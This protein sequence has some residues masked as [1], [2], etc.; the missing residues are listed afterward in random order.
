MRYARCVADGREFYAIVEGDEAVEISDAPWLAHERGRRHPISSVSW[1]PPVL[2]PTFYAA[3]FNYKAHNRHHEELGYDPVKVGDHPE[4]G[5]RAQSA[6]AAHGDA[7]VKPDGVEGRFETEAEVVA[8]IGTTLKHAT[9]HEAKAAV[10]GWTI[11]NDVSARTWQHADRTFYRAKNADT[12][13]PMGPWIE[14]DV[15]PMASTTTVRRNGVV[16]AVFATGD[17]I[18]DPY[19]FIVEMTKYI[20]LRPGDV[21][22]MGADGNTPMGVGDVID[23]EIT[24]IGTLTN[25]VAAE[26]RRTDTLVGIQ[27]GHGR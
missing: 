17:M 25:T 11:G 8:V 16:D 4:V 1:L 21:L 10:F 13:K 9:R 12:F 20:T 27:K 26:G 23:I 18:F 7:I 22:W 3:G 15:D 19:D 24:G 14:T 2:P 6:L 5:Y